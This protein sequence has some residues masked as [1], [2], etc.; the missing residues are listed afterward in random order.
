MTPFFYRRFIILCIFFLGTCL[1]WSQNLLPNPSFEIFTT[2][3]VQYNTGGPLQCTPW[4][5]ATGGTSDYFNACAN[6]N[7]PNLSV[8]VPSNFAGNQLAH[9]G[10]AY[11]GFYAKYTFPYREYVMAPLPAPLT[12]GQF[13]YFSMKNGCSPGFMFMPSRWISLSMV[14]SDTRC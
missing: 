14:C 8:N 1:G 13:Y 11:C 2:C 7:P 9:T 6:P 10:D 12:A 3:P 4:V 5:P